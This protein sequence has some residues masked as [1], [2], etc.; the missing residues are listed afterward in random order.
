MQIQEDISEIARSLVQ[1]ERLDLLE[2]LNG[3]LRIVLEDVERDFTTS[4]SS[5]GTPP[6]SEYNK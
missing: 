1:I 4:N 2:Q 3:R 5:V 6:K